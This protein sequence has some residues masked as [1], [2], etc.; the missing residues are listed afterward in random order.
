MNRRLL[1]ALVPLLA[2][3]AFVAIPAAAQAEPHWYFNGKPLVKKKNVKTEGGLTIGP[4]PG[5]TIT[6]SCKVKDAETIE[7]PGLRWP[8]RRSH[9]SLQSHLLRTQSLPRQLRRGRRAR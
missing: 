7:N 6:V 9:E 3:V 5:T 2:I 8:W 4:I 1:S